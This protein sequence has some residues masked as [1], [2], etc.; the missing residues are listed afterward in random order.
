M[1]APVPFLA[2]AVRSVGSLAPFFTAVGRE[3]AK[4]V[5]SQHGVPTPVICERGHVR[6]RI[7]SDEAAV[8]GDPDRRGDGIACRTRGCDKR[9]HTLSDLWESP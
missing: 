3:V 5:D 1:T 9:A 4:F 8:L 2:A 7:S 6:P